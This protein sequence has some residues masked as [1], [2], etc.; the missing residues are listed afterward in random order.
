MHAARANRM[1]MRATT[2]ARSTGS[3]S[4]MIEMAEL[5]IMAKSEVMEE[6]RHYGLYNTS[7]QQ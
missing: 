6:R 2:N 7:T 1:Y 4:L 3:F 5:I